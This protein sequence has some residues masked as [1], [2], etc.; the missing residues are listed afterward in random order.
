MG[1]ALRAIAYGILIFLEI[2][3]VVLFIM[4]LA[5][6]VAFR[7]VGAR[8]RNRRPETANVPCLI[9]SRLRLI[10][11]SQPKPCRRHRSFARIQSGRTLPHSPADAE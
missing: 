1:S 6:I 2:A 8:K 5:A 11:D 10:A 7:S 3:I 9:G 4:S